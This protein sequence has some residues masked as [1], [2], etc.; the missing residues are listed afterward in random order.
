MEDINVTARQQKYRSI[1]RLRGIIKHVI[2]ALNEYPYLQGFDIDTYKSM[3]ALLLK[4]ETN[5][6]EL[7]AND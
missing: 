3:E 4:L 1:E 7:H 2:E 5:M 6:E